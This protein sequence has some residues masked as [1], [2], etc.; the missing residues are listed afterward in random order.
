MTPTLKKTATAPLIRREPPS[1]LRPFVQ[2]LVARDERP[3]ARVVRILPELRA[4]IQVMAAAPYWLCARAPDAPWRRLPRVALWGPQH[5]WGYGYAGGHVRAFGCALTAAGLAALRRPAWAAVN[6][7]TPLAVAA[8]ALGAA[9]EPVGE[10]DFDAWLA[11][12]L[13]ALQAAFAGADPVDPLPGALDI[14]ATAEAG[15]LDEA[16]SAAGLSERQFRRVFRDR[17]GVSPKRYQRALRVDRMIRQLHARPWELDGHAD[18][19]I[20]FA[21]QPHAI[22]EFRALTGLTPRQYAQ[23]KA[24]GDAAMR[25]VAETG[26]AG[27]ED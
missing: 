22:R 24:K 14:L 16:A 6:E 25:S 21:D 27:P 2:A 1:G 7:V 12:A 9:L 13:P 20:A 15:A 3:E 17:Y 19:P 5:A 10:E 11:R 4:S 18:H 8:P 23:A 26:M